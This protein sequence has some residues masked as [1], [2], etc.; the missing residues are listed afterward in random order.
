MNLLNVKPLSYAF[1]SIVVASISFACSSN[2]G[3]SILYQEGYRAYSVNSNDEGIKDI[4]SDFPKEITDGL[5]AVDIYVSPDGSKIAVG[6]LVGDEIVDSVLYI[7]DAETFEIVEKIEFLELVTSNLYPV[8][9]ASIYELSWSPQSNKIALD[10]AY[11]HSDDFFDSVDPSTLPDQ[12]PMFANELFVFDL[13]TGS[14]ES[15]MSTSAM[16]RGLSWDSSGNQIVFSKHPEFDE[17][18][19]AS[20]SQIYS[21]NVSSKELR[22]LTECLA[23]CL[24]PSVSSDK[25][26]YKLV[27]GREHQ[28]MFI[29]LDGSGQRYLTDTPATYFYQS[30]SP[31]GSQAAFVSDRSG[32]NEVYVINTD[33]SNPRK[34]TDTPADD[35]NPFWSQDSSQI[36]FVS[37]RS[38]SPGVYI[39]SL[40]DPE[41]TP[42]EIVPLSGEF[43]PLKFE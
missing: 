4:S 23:D 25:I 5:S 11:E 27:D 17:D 1:F 39:V 10:I 7:L 28:I 22:Q 30:I 26:V 36:G 3:Y 32:D 37:N 43:V 18:G 8:D 15:L 21:L 34:I 13:D 40:E 31:D 12:V 9:A 33:G 24:D 16:F 35:T 2:T 42:V 41:L 19:D 20:K 14:V 29:N 38:G 6:G